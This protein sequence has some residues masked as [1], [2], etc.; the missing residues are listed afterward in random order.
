MLVTL[1]SLLRAH[2]VLPILDPL[3]N[4]T[5]VHACL[6]LCSLLTESDQ[7]SENTAVVQ[8]SLSPPSL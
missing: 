6:I 4:V 8:Y 2:S 3:M 5:A 7:K 1:S